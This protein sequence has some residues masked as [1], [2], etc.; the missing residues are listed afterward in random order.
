MN[1]RTPRV[2][3]LPL[4]RRPT[5]QMAD[6]EAISRMNAIIKDTLSAASAED[7]K[8]SMSHVFR[9]DQDLSDPDAPGM[10]DDEK[11]R[12]HIRLMQM[13][14]AIEGDTDEAFFM[15]ASAI[16]HYY[17]DVITKDPELSRI[18]DAMRVIE[19]RE[20]LAD[21]YTLEELKHGYEFD[22]GKGPDDWNQLAAD[23]ERRHDDLRVK[24][25]HE[26][27]EDALADMIMNS[28]D[29]FFR[30]FGAGR[31]KIHGSLPPDL[32]SKL[33]AAKTERKNS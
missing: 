24:V 8:A 15:V 9:M 2:G 3:R 19:T 27:G 28:F 1:K 20:G 10:T 5:I 6:P 7:G 30:R 14:R 12:R 26:F 29:E 22:E 23:W 16:E 32:Q 31:E 17:E 21:G 33:D 18:W 11:S 13:Y 25:F 4:K